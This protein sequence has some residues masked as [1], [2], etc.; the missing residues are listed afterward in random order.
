MLPSV[1]LAEPAPGSLEALEGEARELRDK[2]NGAKDAY[3][4]AVQRHE[5]AAAAVG[6]AREEL[7]GI[8]EQLTEQQRTLSTLVKTQYTSSVDMGMLTIL[9]SSETFSGLS[10]ALDCLKEIESKKVSATNQIKELHNTQSEAVTALEQA[11]TEADESAR[12][13]EE[14][15]ARFQDEL[16]GLRP[17]INDLMGEVKAR[18]NGSTGSA[19]LQEA[20]SFLENIDGISE[21]QSAIVRSAYGTGYAGWSRC[22]AWAEAVYRNAGFRMNSYGSAYTDYE[23]N[24]VSEDWNTC[25]AGA[26]VYAS[27]SSGPYSHVGICVLNGGGGPDTIWVMDN[28]GSRSGKALTLTEWLKWQ[29]AVSWNNGRT[30][31]FGWGHPDGVSLT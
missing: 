10:E 17:R 4:G 8:E 24:C 16:D 27:G 28:E 11:M 6:T 20:M 2:I 21:T 5:E 3:I 30:G 15:Q 18:L 13:A 31:W 25:P 19:Q 26:L 1:A 22:E 14:D 12:Q 7:G 23:D 29:T 9:T